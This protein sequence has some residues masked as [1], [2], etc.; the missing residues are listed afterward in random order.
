MHTDPNRGNERRVLQ[1]AAYYPPHLGGMER[2]AEALAGKLAERREVEVLTTAP[3]AP[4]SVTGEAPRVRRFRA[5]E[6]AH[7]PVS[8][9]IFAGLMRAPRGAVWHLHCAHALI[10]EQVMLAARLR[11]QKYLL[12]FHLDVGASG[13]LGRLLPF[14]KKHF[15][16]RAARAAAAVIVLTESQA[17]FM[18]DAYRVPRDR[19]RVVPNGVA[20][21][22]FAAPRPS[23]GDRPLQL[24]FV[25]RLEVQKNVARLIEAL[26]LAGQKIELRVVGDGPLRGEL[27]RQA[28]SHGLTVEFAGPLSGDELLRAY[29]QADAFVMPSDR[30]GMALAVLEAMASGLPVVATDVPGNRELVAGRGLLAAPE[31]A[32]LAAALDRMAGDPDLRLTLAKQCSAAAADHS[33][34]AVADRVEQIYREVYR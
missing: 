9:G 4:P 33:W 26:R 23:G 8:W 21:R 11:G 15:F 32:A 25:G 7:T 30:E 17:E 20:E 3:G 10:A 2:V 14:Y 34:D 27:E 12:H 5:A 24:L 13:P 1:I 18:H 16:A 31:P 19:I 29:Q 22:F 28:A 6:V